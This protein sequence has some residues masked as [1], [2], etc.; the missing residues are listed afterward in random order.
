MTL[1]VVLILLIKFMLN[2]ESY[3]SSMISPRQM[4]NYDRG[5]NKSWNM[6]EYRTP[7]IYQDAA[8]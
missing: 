1:N 4:F 6:S 7:R 2:P 5:L 3:G 8:L